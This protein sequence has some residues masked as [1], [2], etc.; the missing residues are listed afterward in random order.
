MKLIRLRDEDTVD[1]KKYMQEFYNIQHA[2]KCICKNHFS[3]GMNQY[4]VKI[5]HK[6]FQKK[7]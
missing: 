2:L 7:I 1:F 3:M 6:F 4:M 5:N